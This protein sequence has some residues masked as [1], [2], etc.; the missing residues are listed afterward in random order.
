MKNKRGYTFVAEGRSGDKPIPEGKCRLRLIG[1]EE[2][3]LRPKH[4]GKVNCEFYTKE[5]K[6][7]YLPNRDYEFVRYALS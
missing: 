1:S 6:E 5:L 7:Y 2:T 3:L 4:K